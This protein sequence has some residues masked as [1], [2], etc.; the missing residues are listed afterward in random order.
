MQP[1]TPTPVD[2]NHGSAAHRIGESIKNSL[3]PES[4]AETKKRNEALEQEHSVSQ[5][6]RGAAFAPGHH[7]GGTNLTVEQ[8]TR[9]DGHGEGAGRSG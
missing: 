4:S 5:S 9:R 3:V 8:G 1:P 7:V 2:K 6:E